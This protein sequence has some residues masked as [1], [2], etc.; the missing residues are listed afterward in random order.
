ML[1]SVIIP[2]YNRTTTLQR[3]IRSVLVQTYNKFEVIV[4]DDC[5][6]KDPQPYLNELKD[7]RIKLVRHAENLHGGAARNTGVKE[8]SGQFIAFLDSDDEWLPDHLAQRVAQMSKNP[9]CQGIYGALQIYRDGKKAEKTPV[10]PL[11]EGEEMLDYLLSGRCKA[12]TS[13]L[14]FRKSA[15]EKVKFNPSLFQHQD[16]ELN[17]RFHKNFPDGFCCSSEVTAKLHISSTLPSITKKTHH[18]SCLSV[19]KKYSQNITFNNLYRYCLNMAG[20]AIKNSKDHKF[21]K[22]YLMLL[23][24]NRAP[25]SIKEKLYLQIWKSFGIK[26]LKFL[27]GIRPYDF[28]F[29]MK[30]NGLKRRLYG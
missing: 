11:K 24:K 26:G 19:M 2:N 21:I 10:R 15:F 5:S 30:L 6:P 27:I 28:W 17:I 14:F 13:T 9:N 25:R 20:D 1:V 22:E 23:I 8:A 29:Q 12:Q 7:D 4:V 16:Y 3:A 18:T